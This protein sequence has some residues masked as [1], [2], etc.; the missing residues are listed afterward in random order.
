M[1]ADES[2]TPFIPSGYRALTAV[3]TEYGADRV[4][5]W[6]D[7]QRLDVIGRS[8]KTGERF[9]IPLGLWGSEGALE[10]LRTGTF[11]NLIIFVRNFDFPPDSPPNPPDERE[12]F[13]P[14]PIPA[15]VEPELKPAELPERS[16]PATPDL[17]TP[18]AEPAR[19]PGGTEPVHNWEMAACHVDGI[20]DDKVQGRKPLPRNKN[21]KPVV[22]RAIDLM[23]DYFKQYDP[24]SPEDRSIRRWIKD[25]P[26]RTS[27]WWD[28]E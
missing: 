24:P 1:A 3:V 25:N 7:D 6:L 14:R 16:E 10:V 5:R 11:R 28:A 4:R 18:E 19:H 20:V 27:K 2:T 8:P 22:Q 17:Q 26:S 23:K 9:D 15:S 12:N 13:P 21:G